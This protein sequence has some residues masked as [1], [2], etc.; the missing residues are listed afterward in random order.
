M[1]TVSVI[2]PA[3]NASQHLPETIQSVQQQTFTD[4]EMIIVDDCSSDNTFEVACNCA[5]DDPRIKVLR[6]EK[7]AGVSAA[8]NTALDFA[9]GDYIAFLDSDDLWLPQKLEKQLTFMQE[10]HYVLTYT[11]YQQ[12]NTETK[13]LGRSIKAPK[14]MT[15]NAI[16]GNTAIGCLTV[17]VDRKTVGPFH[18]PPISHTEDQCTWQEI[19]RRGY[20]AAYGLQENLALYRE[21]NASLT[22]SK[23]G[24]IKKQWKT[25]REFHQFSIIKSG[26]YFINYAINAVW[27]RL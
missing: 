5:K 15:H 23:L 20:D 9:S 27:K 10:N 18:M 25:Y 21:G 17:M 11:A 13:E 14:K 19:L 1:S 8:R 7:N 12:F 26:F 22:R 2:T 3:Y 4:W 16:Y 6:H 24:A